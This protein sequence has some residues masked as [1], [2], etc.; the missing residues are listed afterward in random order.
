MKVGTVQGHVVSSVKDSALTGRSLLLI[1]ME[2]PTS[3]VQDPIVAADS[4]GVGV[5]EW[6]LIAEG[7]EA[8]FAFENPLPP[9][10]AA[11]VGV[12]DDS[13]TSPES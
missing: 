10:G 9:C 6:V 4:T 8:S 12:I 2:S 1:Q 13:W 5:G 3:K 11:V 7:L